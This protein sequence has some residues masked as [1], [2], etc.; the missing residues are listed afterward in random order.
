MP[1]PDLCTSCNPV[2]GCT[3]TTNLP[4]S[5]GNGNVINWLTITISV[6]GSCGVG[7]TVLMIIFCLHRKRSS[8]RDQDEET[9]KSAADTQLQNLTNYHGRGNEPVVNHQKRHGLNNENEYSVDLEPYDTLT[10][11]IRKDLLNT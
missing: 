5:H 4:D 9:A 8:K 6:C 11:K 2:R 10:L 1:C 7:F 3:V